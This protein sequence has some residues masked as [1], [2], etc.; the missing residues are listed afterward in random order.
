MHWLAIIL[1]AAVPEITD[2]IQ[3]LGA[4]KFADR[5]AGMVALAQL[6]ETNSTAVLDECVRAYTATHDPEVKSRLRT[7]MARTVDKYLYRA[8]RGFLGIRLQPGNII[9]GAGGK[10]V[11]NGVTVPPD[12][13][14]VTG[15]VD[16]SAAAK[17]GMQAND[18]ILAVD[19]QRM[20]NSA[21]FTKYVQSRRPGT[22]VKLRVLR[23][24][25]TNDL[26]AVLGELPQEARDQILS[27][28]GGREYFR[29]WLREQLKSPEFDKGQPAR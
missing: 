6:A 12:A 2:A 22:A 8:P 5:E 13:V 25:Q 11:V 19:D 15:V 10:L 14:W 29:T 1:L 3:K 18:F 17:L 7:T 23:A 9:I 20:T 28:E 26:E 21:A 24:D 16:G 27:E 4:G